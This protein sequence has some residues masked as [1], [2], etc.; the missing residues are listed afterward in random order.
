MA[1]FIRGYTVSG[2]V[3][4]STYIP[5]VESEMQ[6]GGYLLDTNTFLNN[7]ACP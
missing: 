3:T 2:A 1:L 5:T 7:F 6:C 4:M